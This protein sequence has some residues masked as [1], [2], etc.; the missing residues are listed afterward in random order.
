MSKVVKKVKKAVKTGA[1]S[2]A[3][4]VE[5]AGKSIE[6]GVRTGAAS[7][8]DYTRSGLRK[9]EDLAKEATGYHHIKGA[10]ED[11]GDFFDGIGQGLGD[12]FI[13]PQ[14]ESAV[15]QR[16]VLRQQKE[17]AEQAQRLQSNL[18]R[19]LRGE[20]IA[21][22]IA[23]GSSELSGMSGARRRRRGGSGLTSSLQV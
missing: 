12:M 3:G 4:Y 17:L 2:L 21:E 23:G 5:D 7:L 6:K 10:V 9:V 18:S 14:V 8:E 22:V 15:T 20:N 1:S 13:R 16:K 11:V 19:D